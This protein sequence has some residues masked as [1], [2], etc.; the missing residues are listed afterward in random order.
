MKDELFSQLDSGEKEY[1]AGRILDEVKGRM[2]EDITLLETS[3]ALGKNY[4]VFKYQ[5]GKGEYDMV[6]YDRK[7]KCCAVY[8]I[9]HSSEYVR[10]QGR[11][12][13]NEEMLKLTTPRYGKLAGRY[14]LY[15][16]QPMDTEDGIA[17]R[18]AEEFLK[19]LPQ[20]RL[21]SGLEKKRHKEIRE[22]EPEE[23]E[24]Q[25]EEQPEMSPVM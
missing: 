15:L 4:H 7:N 17:Y 18:N 2:L 24:S 25:E 20:I 5:F 23:N 19:M 6:I 13:M 12:L 1:V 14:V 11:H 16:G 3:K 10:E 8:E 9:K 22:D 21:D